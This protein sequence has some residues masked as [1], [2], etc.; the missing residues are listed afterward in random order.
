MLLCLFEKNRLKIL[1]EKKGYFLTKFYFYIKCS[2]EISGKRLFHFHQET[3]SLIGNQTNHR[4]N[5][6]LPY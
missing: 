4:T 6:F 1:I 5:M 3:S 2:M